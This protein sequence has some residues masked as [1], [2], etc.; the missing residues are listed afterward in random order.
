MKPVSGLRLS[1]VVLSLVLCLQALSI[2]QCS[3]ARVSGRVVDQSG[4]PLP[5]VTIA[6]T[7]GEQRR[8]VVSGDVTMRVGGIDCVG[9]GFSTRPPPP[10]YIDPPVVDPRVPA[11]SDL[12]AY[13]VLQRRVDDDAPFECR[14]RYR[15]TVL[16]AATSPRY[17]KLFLRT[18]EV[19]LKPS[20][21]ISV[22][23]GHEYIAW[24]AW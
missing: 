4:A 1:P 13:F 10:F 19:R 24:L 23:I 5:G 6:A 8:M 11:R 9:N 18:I 2:A 15:A 22:G 21:I 14:L 17:G 12:V 20:P 16:R 7:I 3:V